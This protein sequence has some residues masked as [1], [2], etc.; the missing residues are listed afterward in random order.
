VSTRYNRKHEAFHPG[1]PEPI[2]EE[3]DCGALR[4]HGREELDLIVSYDVE[5]RLGAEEADTGECPRPRR[6]ARSFSST[7]RASI[8]VATAGGMP[9]AKS[10]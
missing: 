3:I 6:H 1:L 4:L 7:M 10:R 2:V 5:Y 8:C 9:E